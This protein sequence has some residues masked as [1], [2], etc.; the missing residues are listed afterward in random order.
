MLNPQYAIKLF[1]CTSRLNPGREV[2]LL[3]AVREARSRSHRFQGTLKSVLAST[4][5]QWG[6]KLFR[7]SKVAGSRA[8]EQEGRAFAG[9]SPEK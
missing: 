7:V 6:K 3:S 2:R 1:G 9:D 5:C 8:L 4:G